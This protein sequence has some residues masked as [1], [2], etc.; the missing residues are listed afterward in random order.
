MRYWFYTK[1]PLPVVLFEN[2]YRISIA[3]WLQVLSKNENIF[4]A[5]YWFPASRSLIFPLIFPSS[6]ETSASRE[7]TGYF[8]KIAKINSH[9]EKPMGP[10]P[11]N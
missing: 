5:G 9:R 1:Y 11:K 2:M 3:P 7:G 8:L 6:W 4:N 10:D